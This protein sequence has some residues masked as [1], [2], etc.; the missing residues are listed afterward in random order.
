[1]TRWAPNPLPGKWESRK[2]RIL[3]ARQRLKVVWRHSQ[4]RRAAAAA[5]RCEGPFGADVAMG[6]EVKAEEVQVKVEEVGCRKNMAPSDSV[7]AGRPAFPKP[8]SDAAGMTGSC[9]AA[10]RWLRD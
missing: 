9:A 3:P 4:L 6:E 5:R 2:S 1:M 7:C 10:G 8:A